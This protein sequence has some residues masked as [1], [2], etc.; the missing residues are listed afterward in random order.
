ME[1]LL[2]GFVQETYCLNTFLGNKA[3]ISL[4]VLHL[5]NIDDTGECQFFCTKLINPYDEMS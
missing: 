5:G 1:V 4:T 2:D 3:K